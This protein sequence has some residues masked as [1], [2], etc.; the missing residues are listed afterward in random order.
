VMGSLLQE[1]G[2]GGGGSWSSSNTRNRNA[3]IFF[4]SGDFKYD[5]IV[6][7]TLCDCMRAILA[8]AVARVDASVSESIKFSSK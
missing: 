6:S 4:C 5:K 3:S 8:G 2:M 7:K 1:R